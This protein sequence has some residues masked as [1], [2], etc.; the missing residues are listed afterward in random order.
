[1]PTLDILV[2]HFCEPIEIVRRLLDSIQSQR[3]IQFQDV[4]VTIAND[5]FENAL[6]A[7]DLD[8]Y[9]FQIDYLTYP[10]RG[11]CATRNVLL[12]HAAATYVMF[13]D[14]DDMFSKNYALSHLLAIL[15]QSQA[16]IIGASFDKEIKMEDGFQYETISNQIRWLH[17]KIF[18][19]A[20]LIQKG[21][22]FPDELPFSGDMYFLNLAYYLT[23]R[24]KWLQESL[25]IWKWMPVSVTRG[26]TFYYVRTYSQRVHCYQLLLV[27]WR[28]RKDRPNYNRHLCWFIRLMYADW[29]SEDMHEAPRELSD[30]AKE[31][32]RGVIK[33]YYGSFMACPQKLRERYVEEPA[34]LYVWLGS[35]VS[36]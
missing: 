12:D 20:F 16:D 25:Y 24:I 15:D 28:R 7:N 18:R 13:C 3:G 30:K 22:R 34:M 19:R 8:G 35:I 4:R 10:H 5:G 26:K 11:V 21:I 27:E 17:C 36:D 29:F 31:E 1:M 14:C 33:K 23:D 32:I 9:S 6:S 2:N